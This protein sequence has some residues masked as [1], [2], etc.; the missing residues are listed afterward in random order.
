MVER[1]VGFLWMSTYPLTD[2]ILRAALRVHTELGPGLV[3][4]VYED[5]LEIEFRERGIQFRRQASIDVMYRGHRMKDSFK[6]DFVVEDQVILELKAVALLNEAH[7]AQ[8]IN[9]VRLTKMPVG[10]L[11]NFNV[12]RLKYGIRRIEYRDGGVRTI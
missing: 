5:C 1:E 4:R 7:L 10:L 12:Q 11:L 2:P 9:Y 3:E 6:A 8:I